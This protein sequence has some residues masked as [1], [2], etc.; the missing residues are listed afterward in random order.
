MESDNIFKKCFSRERRA[1]SMSSRRAY[2]SALEMLEM[3]GSRKHLVLFLWTTVALTM[4]PI[5]EPSVYMRQ[6]LL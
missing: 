5:L 6:Q 3:F 4:L 2:S 1:R